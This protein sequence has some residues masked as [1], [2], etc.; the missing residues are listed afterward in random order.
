MQRNTARTIRMNL[1]QDVI[2]D[3]LR[4]EGPRLT[5]MELMDGR[6]VFG[7]NK[8]DFDRALTDLCEAD[9]VR[10]IDDPKDDL[11]ELVT[12]KPKVSR[13]L[14]NAT[15]MIVSVYSGKPG[16]ACGCRGKHSKDQRTINLIVNK[17]L[18]IQPVN[19]RKRGENHWFVQT[20]TRLYIAYWTE[21]MFPKEAK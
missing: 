15:D 21:E 9:R 14:D 8:T 18:K 10:Y 16:C 5:Y 1:A 7:I 3:L 17:M 4:L 6:K 13:Y 11:Y 12:A 20:E 2:L 19:E